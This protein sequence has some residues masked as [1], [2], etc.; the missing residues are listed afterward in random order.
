MTLLFQNFMVF[1]YIIFDIV[2]V[3]SHILLQTKSSENIHQQT[4]SFKIHCLIKAYA[5]KH[6]DMIVNDN[7]RCLHPF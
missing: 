4:L 7:C 1:R 3:S 5:L 6:N 2:I